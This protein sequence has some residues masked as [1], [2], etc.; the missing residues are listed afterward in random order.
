MVDGA[1]S[2]ILG[3]ATTRIGLGTITVP[4]LHKLLTNRSRR[5]V[6]AVDILLFKPNTSPEDYKKNLQEDIM[7]CYL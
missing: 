2:E 6:Y 3:V 7:Q 1:S 4:D 5:T